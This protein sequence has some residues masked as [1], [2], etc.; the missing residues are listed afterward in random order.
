MD[1]SG[2][3]LFPFFSFFSSALIL[4]LPLLLLFNRKE[5]CCKKKSLSLFKVVCNAC[6]LNCPIHESQMLCCNE[7]QGQKQRVNCNTSHKT[8]SS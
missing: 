6:E 5:N 2:I 8:G 3:S 7:Y 4:R 1:L